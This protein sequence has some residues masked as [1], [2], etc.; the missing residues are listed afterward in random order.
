MGE[1]G[2][3]DHPTKGL[4]VICGKDNVGTEIHAGTVVYFEKFAAKELQINSRRVFAVK[5]SDIKAI[6]EVLPEAAYQ[7]SR[8]SY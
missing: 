1:E 5:A 7:L 4:I 6:E 8:N 2:P 3:M